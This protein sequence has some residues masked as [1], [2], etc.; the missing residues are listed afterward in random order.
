M[1]AALLLIATAADAD[2]IRLKNGDRITGT[3][4]KR[5]D[6]TMVVATPYAGEVKINWAEIEGVDF[7][8]PKPVLL[9]DSSRVAVS[10]LGPPAESTDTAF[11]PELD[12]VAFVNP[13]R[14]EYGDGIEY[15]GNAKVSGTYTRGNVDN[16]LL[17]GDGQLLGR[18]KDY[19]FSVFGQRSYGSNRTGRTASNATLRGD[20]DWF[21][22]EK[23]FIYGRGSGEYDEFKDLRQRWIAG[24]GYGYRLIDTPDTQFSVQGG[25]DYVTED[26]FT[27]ADANYAAL[28]W[29]VRYSQWLFDRRLQTFHEQ[30]GYQALSARENTLV[31]TRTG[32]RIPL[33]GGF[34]V[35]LQLNLDWDSKPVTGRK[36]VDTVW[37]LGAGYAW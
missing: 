33:T 30:D 22:G 29:A 5:A 31:R 23:S 17:Y 10:G 19:R 3:V 20:Y 4:V 16:D 11:R 15:S 32:L 27:A 28:G 6:A 18:A 7:D 9:Q 13:T 36:S 12:T 8:S 26:Y 14:A 21:T 34:N 25:G 24:G 37:L 2:V 1:A 35:S